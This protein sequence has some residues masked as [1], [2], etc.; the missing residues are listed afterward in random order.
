VR[1][2]WLAIATDFRL[3]A[4]L[5][6]W[7][8]ADRNDWIADVAQ[9]LAAK[10]SGKSVLL[11]QG[12]RDIDARIAAA[13]IPFALPELAPFDKGTYE[14]EP[15]T[16]RDLLTMAVSAVLGG[17]SE[18]S[19]GDLAAVSR[20]LVPSGAAVPVASMLQYPDEGPQLSD[21]NDGD[22][23]TLPPAPTWVGS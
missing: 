22:G 14:T 16:S 23:L 21:I 10:H 20:A 19:E 1:G 9:E 7:E 15:Y 5:E 18:L 12:I 4:L 11:P 8:G 3:D 6:P 17:T 2:A 13:G